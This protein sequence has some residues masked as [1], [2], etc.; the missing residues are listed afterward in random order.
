M[1][2]IE[3][4]K[5]LEEIEASPRTRIYR[6]LRLKDNKFV[7]L[8]MPSHE[9]PTNREI[10]NLEHEYYLLKQF[11][12]PGIIRAYE[13]ISSHLIPILV[14]ED[15]QGEALSDFL[16]K[17]PVDLEKFFYIAIQLIDV[18]QVLYENRI[19][20]K[21]IKPGNILIEPINLAI[22]LI[23]LNISSQLMEEIQEQ[24][25]PD[26]LEGTLAYISPEQTGRMNR[27]I[28][29]R[30]DFYSLGVTFFEM[31]TGFVPF[32][33][34]DPLELIYAHLAKAP[35]NVSELNPAIPTIVS[36]IIAKLLAKDPQ[37]RYAHAL[38]LKAD[39][40]N[41][42]LQWRAKQRID[43]FNLGQNDIQDKLQLSHKLYGREQQIN[44]L[45]SE[46]ERVSQGASQLMLVSGYPGIGK[47]S[48]VNEIH[49]LITQ[50]KG[51]FISG[52]FSQLKAS[53][54]SAVVEAFQKIVQQLLAEP[55]AKLQQFK[56]RLLEALGNN[57]QIIIDIIP[58]IELII[59]SQPAV[60]ILN[61]QEAQNR[62]NL[63]FQN[64]VQVFAQQE[65][66]LVIFLDDLQWADI[67]SLKFIENIIS[68]PSTHHLFLIGAYRDNEVDEI[69]PLSTVLQ[70]LKQVE[71]VYQTIILN[72][73]QQTDIENLLRDMFVRS[74]ETVTALA[75]LLLT[76]TQGNPFFINEFLRMLYHEK[77]L[78]FIH[79]EAKWNWN[80]TEI[81][82]QNITENVVELLVNKIHRLTDASQQTLKLAACFG[83]IFD[84]QTLSSICGQSFEKVA[85]QLIEAQKENLIIPLGDTYKIAELLKEKCVLPT[86]L[87]QKKLAYRFVHDRVQQ[88][89][90]SLI[91]IEER[92]IVHLDIGRLLLKEQPLAEN[93]ERLF[94]LLDHLN[95]GLLLL[96]NSAEM[97]QLARYNLWAGIKALSSVAYPVALNYF[98]I[99]IA[100]LNEN[101]W[102]NNYVMT[103]ALHQGHLQCSYILG[104]FAIGDRDFP[105]IEAHA[106][107]KFDKIETYLIKIQAYSSINDYHQV[108]QI[109]FKALNLFGVKL[110]TH[111]NVATVL[112]E[113]AKIYYQVGKKSIADMDKVLK[114]VQDPEVILQQKLYG[115]AIGAAYLTGNDYLYSFIACRII[116]ISLKNGYTE[117]TPFALLVYAVVLAEKFNKFD[118]AFAFAD[119]SKK[120]EKYS[121]TT[122]AKTTYLRGYYIN[123][124]Q[125]HLKDSL[126]MFSESLDLCRA[127]GNLEYA[128][129]CMNR[130]A[131]LYVLGT[132]LAE[133][134][135]EC[136][137]A[138]NFLK[139]LKNISFYH[140]L[141]FIRLIVNHLQNNL[142]TPEDFEVV[143][144]EVINRASVLGLSSYVRYAHLFYILGDF[145]NALKWSEEFYI[146]RERNRG[147]VISISTGMLI[148]ALSLTHYY[149][150]ATFLQRWRYRR[151]LKS[152]LKKFT[153]YQKVSPQNLRFMYLLICAEI[154]S[155]KYKNPLPA[156][157]LYDDAIVAATNAGYIN[158]V[159]LINE[160]AARFYIRL[161][162]T[163]SSKFYILQAY[164]AY[165]RW[166]ATYK[167]HLLEKQYPDLINAL[168]TTKGPTV[169]SIT[170]STFSSQQFDFMSIL[171]ASQTIASEIKL[172]EL[173]QKLLQIAFE[174]SG[175]QRGALLFE[176]Q[177]QLMVVA[178]GDNEQSIQVNLHGMSL[179]LHPWLSK[180]VLTY[181]QRTHKNLILNDENEIQKFHQDSTIAAS[182]P[183]SL[184]CIPILQH[185]KSLGYMYLENRLTANTFTEKRLEVL[186]LLGGQTAISLENAKLYLA[187]TRFVPTAFLNLI[188]KRDIEEV[189]L[190]DSIKRDITVLFNDIRNF[191]TL[192]ESITP[193]QAFTFINRYWNFMAPIIRQ[194]NGYIDQFQ[195][196]AI[197]AIFPG[198]PDDG[199]Q[200][201][202]AL[203]QALGKFNEQQRKNADVVVNMGVGINTGSAMLG[204][205]GEEERHL[206]GTVS[207][208]ANTASRIEGLNKVYHS[209][210]LLSGETV[211]AL[212]HAKFNRLRKIDKLRLKGK[213]NVTEIY[214]AIDWHAQFDPENLRLY[215]NEFEN[216]YNLYIN[217]N[218]AEA[219]ALFANCLSKYPQDY[220]TQ[221][222]HSRCEK[223]LEQGVPQ[224]WDGT[225]VM[226]TK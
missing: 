86:V 176:Q 19:I 119:L 199:L 72:S 138:V 84:I 162:L 3:G 220:P 215:L 208:V 14:L 4:Y 201:A 115:N 216:A 213:V 205:I 150:T 194:Y 203:C 81:E 67:T 127:A 170:S 47:T 35:P 8:K 77:L 124:W 184:V 212:Q 189:R 56:E 126:A 153:I 83:H 196:D 68:N 156:Q 192:T 117:E 142:S 91:A 195:G 6:C 57:G 42:A 9:H 129:Y 116:N 53:P 36:A 95:Q 173:L 55:E 109:I 197:I 178:E 69:H 32:Q 190:G 144:R 125:H 159:A 183:K 41:C 22:K 107:T 130:S 18:L 219:R 168:A 223:F 186:S 145:P 17:Q 114:P 10:A 118:L 103:L 62:F 20:H 71:I 148:Y 11:N 217:G 132:N 102:D 154:A 161:G 98:K 146:R 167:C 66:P 105:I 101:A 21:D 151:I 164:Y 139:E 202:L 74:N 33:A 49:K 92:Q 135:T 39:L 30:T 48:L 88:A 221:I 165:Q 214:E 191:T 13:L 110:K 222:L 78:Y 157:R 111:L 152:I 149:P 54:Y 40:E 193:E 12:Q 65:H 64:F 85:Q 99:G 155:I 108:L 147:I 169:S 58:D 143:I 25:P 131:V 200:A 198:K 87:M 225:T 181:V 31:L 60:P 174:N 82:K 97:E 94:D 51:Y 163:G 27:P 204:I 5:F 96:S 80:I 133:V 120:L 185:G 43:N 134:S 121:P 218:F 44:I 75:K 175:A 93:D 226:E 106:K 23:D 188:G 123:P 137:K 52:K 100:L 37:N 187:S 34:I 76:K 1:L 160:C 158:Y 177:E 15:S 140:I 45:L 179:E 224:N 207:D 210:I 172:H 90:Y 26:L 113:M 79:V 24:T 70:R 59:G 7:I 46:F 206:P 122:A 209:H 166:G 38:H 61:P 50:Y 29:Y 28:D 136:D 104:E 182:N 89:A 128:G 112:V 211:A 171:K 63:I 180:S 2:D 16:H 73:L 141:E